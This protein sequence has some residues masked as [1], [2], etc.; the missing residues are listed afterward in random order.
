VVER[1]II[2]SWLPAI[3]DPIVQEPYDYYEGQVIGE[4]YLDLAQQM[5]R[6]FQS[7]WAPEMHTAF[8]NLVITPVL[9]DQA[10]IDAVFDELSV[11]LDRVKSL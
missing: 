5:P 4:L 10:D 1:G 9:Q 6:I 11:E 2:P 7:P 8:Q 3:E